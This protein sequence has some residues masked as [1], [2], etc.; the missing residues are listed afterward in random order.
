MLMTMM[1]VVMMM[2]LLIVTHQLVGI[3]F[4]ICEPITHTHTHTPN[5]KWRIGNSKRDICL[6]ENNEKRAFVHSEPIL[7]VIHDPGF[8]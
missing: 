3:T 6:V 8:L 4:M 1:M 2:M 7:V 5:D